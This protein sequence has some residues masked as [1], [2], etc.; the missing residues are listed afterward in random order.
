MSN[1]TIREFEAYPEAGFV[2]GQGWIAVLWKGRVSIDLAWVA[3][4]RPGQFVGTTAV[5]MAGSGWQ[6]EVPIRCAYRD[7]MKMW[8]EARGQAA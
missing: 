5:I 2:E 1:R 6:H 3:G 8:V 4:A 7:F